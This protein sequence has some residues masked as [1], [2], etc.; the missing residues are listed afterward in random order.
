MAYLLDT[1]IFIQA[2]NEYYGFDI[3]PGF[4]DWL[5]RQ[6]EVGQVFSIE[7]VKAELTNGQDELSDW[8]KQKGSSFFL[9]FDQPA[10]I[11][12]GKI[13]T[14]VQSGPYRE[15]VKRDFLSVAD[16][17]LIA[18]AKAHKHTVVSHEV[19]ILEERKKIKIP[20]V[21]HAFQVP[22]IRTFAM[23]REEEALFVLP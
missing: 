6:N 9:P 1:N 17:L 16:P 3:C 11:A 10:S 23:L 22:C 19:F 2:K 8:A 12:M 5:E 4:W 18:Y 15:N 14:W 20:V 13:S 7:S 21:C